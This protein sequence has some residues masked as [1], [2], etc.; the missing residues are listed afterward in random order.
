LRRYPVPAIPDPAQVAE[1]RQLIAAGETSIVELK[2]NPPRPAELA[3]RMA[4]IAN[5]RLGGAIIFGVEEESRRI[6]GVK[7]LQQT[8]DIIE[9]A[10]RLIRPQLT[11]AAPEPQFWLLDG[12][13]IVIIEIPANPGALYQAG[14]AFPIRKGTKTFPMSDTEVAAHLARYGILRWETAL[15]PRATLADLDIARIERFLAP[16]AAHSA[17]YQRFASTADLLV[18]LE[19]AAADP[20][21]GELRPTNAAL[22]LF[23]HDPQLYLPQSEVVCIQYADDLGAGRYLDRKNLRGP[24]P[25]LIDQAALFLDR[26]MNVG[27]QITGFTRHDLPDYPLEALREAV[28]NAIVHRDYSLTEETIRI[29]MYRTRVEIHSP[30]LLLPGIT[31]PDLVQLRVRS[32]PRNFVVAS[33]LREIP[34][35]MERIGSGIRFMFH[36]MRQMQLPDPE[37]VEQHEFI[38][39]FRTHPVAVEASSSPVQSDL[40]PRQLQGLAHI[41]AKGSLTTKEYM[42]ATG[43]PART[44]YRDLQDMVQKGVISNRGNRRTSRY[45]LP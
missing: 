35:Y 19:Y 33:G 40:S 16:R 28:V 29:F 32:K 11:L 7:D 17:R 37:L 1:L 20:A 27:A 45:Y 42:E 8:V 24:L 30:G 36:E 18:H 31:I 10:L 23:G 3:Y 6:T 25:E 44:A 39:I 34:G 9:D 13:A 2:I 21:T 12:A 38:V 15:C 43:A 41:R 14:G 26:H 22:L 4:G 5:R